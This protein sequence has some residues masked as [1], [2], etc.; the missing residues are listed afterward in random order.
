MQFWPSRVANLENLPLAV[1]CLFP[2]A[3]HTAAEAKRRS[4]VVRLFMETPGFGSNESVKSLEC[5]T[6]SQ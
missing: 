4:L 1:V 6:D 3:D 2:E 5:R